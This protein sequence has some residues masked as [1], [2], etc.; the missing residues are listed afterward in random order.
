MTTTT[1][2]ATILI[3]CVWFVSERDMEVAIQQLYQAY[4]KCHKGKAKTSQAQ[5]Y[6]AKLIDNIF[7]THS[8][9]HSNTYQPQPYTCF[10]A[11]NGVK[12][13][14][15]Y[16]ADFSDRVVHHWL[17]DKLE[18]IINPKF[19][20]YSYANQV[21]KGTH[22]G[23]NA[24]QKMLRKV[25][26][27]NYYLQLDIHNFFY[28]ID[29]KILLSL[30]AKYLKNAIKKHSIHPE[31]AKDYYQ[32]CAKILKRPQAKNQLSD[33]QLS[34]IP[35]HKQLRNIIAG[36]GLPIRNITSQCF[37][38]VY[39]NELDQFIKHELNVKYFVR[40]VDDFVLLGKQSELQH[41][42]Q[43]IELFLQQKLCLRLKPG[44][45]LKPINSGIDFLGYIIYLH[46][47]LTRKSVIHNFYQKLKKWHQDNHIKTKNGV[48]F[49]LTIDKITHINSLFFSYLGHFKPAKAHKVLQQKIQQFPWLSLFFYQQNNQYRSTLHN[50]FADNFSQ[51]LNFF[52]Y[53]FQDFVVITQIGKAF[54]L[55][56][57]TTQ[58]PI[59]QLT[60]YL[61]IQ[62]SNKQS[63]VFISEQGYAH[64]RLKQRRVRQLF[65]ANHQ[66]FTHNTPH[67]ISSQ[68]ISL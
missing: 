6:S 61:K 29:K 44:T 63:Y 32:L 34:T 20:Y 60:A 33:A 15:I 36:K 17:V 50:K 4:K 59:R 41:W 18:K 28:S 66:Q 40:F 24:L 65:I 8:V 51:Q 62:Q 54:I 16:A 26:T 31:Q 27:D 55:G 23:V 45:L 46:Y 47:Q 22:F 7:A 13:R 42:Q 48:L 35:P 19:I 68:A 11:T 67:C 56:N 43:A 53:F 52:N 25:N 5:S 58:K 9:L 1:T 64:N 49:Q 3:G 39:L 12:P 10:V 38:N 2:I 57:D 14:E 37:G 30:L 21:G